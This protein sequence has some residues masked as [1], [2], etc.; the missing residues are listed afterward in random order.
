MVNDLKTP[1]IITDEVKFFVVL[2]EGLLFLG[3]SATVAIEDRLVAK[4]VLSM[5]TV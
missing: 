2:E 3:D 1:K 4:P 5:L